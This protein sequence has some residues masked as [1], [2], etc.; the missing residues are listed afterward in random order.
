MRSQHWLI[1]RQASAEYPRGRLLG[2]H[3][4]LN[5]IWNT[6]NRRIPRFVRLT[7][8][9]MRMRI[10]ACVKNVKS[11]AAMRPAAVRKRVAGNNNDSVRVK[12]IAINNIP[13]TLCNVRPR[14]RASTENNLTSYLV[15]LFFF[16]FIFTCC[17]LAS[18]TVNIKRFCFVCVSYA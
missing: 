1:R 11:D 16:F 13:P 8:I 3:I 4:C 18:A 6:I 5:Q 17:T 7:T 9:M 15:V 14:A 2:R 12:L 10:P